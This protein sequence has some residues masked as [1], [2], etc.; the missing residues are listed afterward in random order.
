MQTSSNT[1]CINNDNDIRNNL[2]QGGYFCIGL[3]VGW[4][5]ELLDNLWMDIFEFF[6]NDT[7]QNIRKSIWFCVNMY[8]HF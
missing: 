3:L 4:L 5:A 6:K 7:P 8:C 2:C 1:S